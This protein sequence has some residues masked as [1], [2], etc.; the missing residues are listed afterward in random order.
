MDHCVSI[1]SQGLVDRDKPCPI[2]DEIHMEDLES[3]L[4]KALT[5][6]SE[7]SEMIAAA[8]IARVCGISE[9]HVMN[10]RKRRQL[11]PGKQFGRVWRW[12]A[13]T[14]AKWLA[15]NAKND[16]CTAASD[17]DNPDDRPADK[18]A[19]QSR[20]QPRPGARSPY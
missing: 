18:K 2:K 3:Q 9:R 14:V 12:H 17:V 19:S 4:V 6:R 16:L 5:C 7:G 11:P 20:P 10:L 13:R 1:S 15:G 8:A